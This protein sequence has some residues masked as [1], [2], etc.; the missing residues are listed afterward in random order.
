MN[1][2]P[3]SSIKLPLQVDEQ[4]VEFFLQD[5]FKDAM[6]FLGFKFEKKI[7]PSY[8]VARIQIIRLDANPVIEILIMI[9][10]FFVLSLTPSS[11]L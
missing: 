6:N 4:C 7:L 2:I 10:L 1:V 5:H 3:L 9:S 11:Y 8:H